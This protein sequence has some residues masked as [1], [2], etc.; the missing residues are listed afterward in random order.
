MKRRLI[1][2]QFQ[3]LSYQP[4]Y[5]GASQKTYQNFQ[6]FIQVWYAWR[7]LYFTLFENVILVY[8]CIR[9]ILSLLLP[10]CCA[11][12]SE[13]LFLCLFYS[14][15]LGYNIQNSA[16]WNYFNSYKRQGQVSDVF[17]QIQVWMISPRG[18][19][20]FLGCS[21]GMAGMVKMATTLYQR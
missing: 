11:T 13:S 5:M 19:F 8:I 7:L 10:I 15:L 2:K 20:F 3:G 6:I 21:Q 4:S 12:F 17:M 18:I 9:F 1:S 16:I 14:P